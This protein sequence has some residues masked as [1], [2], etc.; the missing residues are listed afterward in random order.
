MVAD[1]ID[2]ALSRR[3]IAIIGSMIVGFIAL[4]LPASAQAHVFQQ[5]FVLLLPTTLYIASGVTVVAVAD[6]T[7]ECFLFFLCVLPFFVGGTCVALDF[8]NG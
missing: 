4:L 8:S 2:N 1:Q 3:T 7:L 5:G 6:S